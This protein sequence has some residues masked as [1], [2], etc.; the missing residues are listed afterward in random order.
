MA[1][2]LAMA[3]SDE[4][5]PSWAA[6]EGSAG[7]PSPRIFVAHER[8]F[9]AQAPLLKFWHDAAGWCPSCE[10]VFMVLEA[11]R[12]PYVMATSPLTGYL[13]PGQ[14]KPAEFLAIRPNGI[15]PVIQLARPGVAGEPDGEPIAHAFRI[16]EALAEHFPDEAALPRTPLRRE[17]ALLFAKLAEKLCYTVEG[18]QSL[19]PVMDDLEV[20]L[21][22]GREGVAAAAEA[23]NGYERPWTRA[24]AWRRQESGDDG[25]GD[26]AHHGGDPAA[27][28]FFFGR[29]P[30]AADLMLLPWLERADA[31]LA[32]GG[33]GG[34]QA[35]WPAAAALLAAAA[36]P[37]VCAYSEVG[38][39]LVT[40]DGL[41]W[42]SNPAALAPPPPDAA[43]AAVEAAASAPLARCDA[44][45]R[46]CANHAAVARFA[47][48]GAGA[49]ASQRDAHLHGVETAC[50][51]ATDDALRI[52]IASLLM[53][54]SED[55]RALHGAMVERASAVLRRNGSDATRAAGGALLFLA[56]NVG[57]PRDM[58]S[59]AATA[60]RTHTTLAAALLF[61]GA[62]AL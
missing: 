24:L 15:L 31:R 2:G 60:T 43:V 40:L 17:C 50:V 9:E 27:G 26:D 52:V 33:Y 25:D 3:D 56:R 34:L 57:V 51:E 47:C 58:A 39:D 49:G 30:C 8:L 13:K 45:A 16:C 59:A 14:T 11:M 37:G 18:Q 10:C 54:P 46:L 19:P 32:R 41:Y 61:E 55:S 36:E 48:R 12:I 5:L 53:D 7:K 20:A 29:R 38:L 28:P 44:G 4:E 35:R 22:G 6:L 21:C 42:R 62:A 23:G 1:A